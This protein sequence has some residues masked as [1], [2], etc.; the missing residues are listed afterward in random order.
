MTDAIENAA[1][2][3]KRDLEARRFNPPQVLE[4]HDN[5][6]D[7]VIYTRGYGEKY[8]SEDFQK[9]LYLATAAYFLQQWKVPEEKTIQAVS[10]NASLVQALFNQ[11]EQIHPDFVKDGI[12]KMRQLETANSTKV[13]DILG[14]QVKQQALSRFE[15][16]FY[17]EFGERGPAQTKPK[18]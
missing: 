9:K 10:A 8:L 6:V 18:K 13:K 7:A 16:K 1:K 15:R 3:R 11:K 5:Y 14:S 2:E 4:L 17:Q 12:Q